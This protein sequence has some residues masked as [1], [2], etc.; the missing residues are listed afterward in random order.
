MQA[1]VMHLIEVFGVHAAVVMHSIYIAV[2]MHSIYIAVVMHSIYIAAWCHQAS[3]NSGTW[4][5]EA[6]HCLTHPCKS[7]MWAN[8]WLC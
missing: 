6:P 1:A 4:L 8:P 7:R 3:A 5:L 2:A